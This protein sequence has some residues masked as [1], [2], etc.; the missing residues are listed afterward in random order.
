MGR[1]PGSS[2]WF[3][4]RVLA[5]FVKP[6]EGRADYTTYRARRPD[7]VVGVLEEGSFKSEVLAAESKLGLVRSRV[8]R[9][10]A[11]PDRGRTTI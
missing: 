1:G 8:E 9:V 5:M 10:R 7:C 4:P 3:H 11:L 6:T 2:S